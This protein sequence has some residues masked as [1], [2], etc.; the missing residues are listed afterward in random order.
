MLK[1]KVPLVKVAGD[2]STRMLAEKPALGVTVKVLLVPELTTTAPDGLILPLAPA[3]AVM[4]S[5]TGL[6]FAVTEVFAF[7]VKVKGSL[8]PEAPPVQP[9]N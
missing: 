3:E 2:P 7:I 9:V 1:V 8:L 6:K 5:V 4:V